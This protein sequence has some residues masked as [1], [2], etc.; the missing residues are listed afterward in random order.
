MGCKQVFSILLEATGST[1]PR[2]FRESELF[3]T[4]R[5]M[6]IIP[7]GGARFDDPEISVEVGTNE[8]IRLTLRIVGMWCPACAWLIV[9]SLKKLPGVAKAECHFST[10][11][12]TCEYDPLRVSPRQIRTTV[13]RLGYR[14]VD[15]EEEGEGDEFRRGLLEFAICAFL[16]MNIMMMSYG[17]YAGL[18]N[19][20]AAEGV[21]TLSWP[22]AV[23]AGFVLLYGGRSVFTRAFRGVPFGAFS[24]ETL[25][26]VGA[27]S[28]FLLSFHNL[29]VGS[30]HLYFDTA[31]M[32]ITLALLG[33]TLDGR[34]RMEV[35]K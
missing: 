16:T 25:I 33:K 18:L 9:A 2:N 20:T 13:E 21:K 1:D 3:K 11:R 26:S 31:A 8:T 19:E 29:L 34:A 27:I 12:L 10:D 32:L 35:K 22:I 15:P 4:C 24:M 5:E 17:V 28:A 30:L 6:G 14:T 7:K 23:M